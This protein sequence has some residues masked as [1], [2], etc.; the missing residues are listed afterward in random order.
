MK[1]E[2]IASGKD[3]L[4]DIYTES[5]ISDLLKVIKNNDDLEEFI[6]AKDKHNRDKFVAEATL[7]RQNGIVEQSKNIE[8][9]EKK[10]HN[11]QEEKGIYNELT[12]RIKEI[13]DL[14]PKNKQQ[15]FKN[16]LNNI[17]SKDKLQQAVETLTQPKKGFNGFVEKVIHGKQLKEANAK[18]SE[19]MTF[20][21]D[22]DVFESKSELIQCAL[23]EK[24][25]TIAL[26]MA[27]EKIVKEQ[28]NIKQYQQ[29][30][31]I[32][33]DYIQQD[34]NQYDNGPE[35]KQN[36]DK[37]N[38]IIRQFAEQ[39]GPYITNPPKISKEE[40]ANNGL[41]EE[42]IEGQ[43]MQSNYAGN[44]RSSIRRFYEGLDRPAAPMVAFCYGGRT[45]KLAQQEIIDKLEDMGI[46]AVSNTDEKA[47]DPTVFVV[48]EQSIQA[49]FMAPDE[50]LKANIKMIEAICQSEH[51]EHPF[52]SNPL[53]RE[54]L[55]VAV[56]CDLGYN[57]SSENIAM[58]NGSDWERITKGNISEYLVSM[59]QE[60]RDNGQ[61][62]NELD[63][64]NAEAFNKGEAFKSVFHGGKCG[65]PYVVLCNEDNMNFVYGAGGACGD[66]YVS[67]HK[68]DDWSPDGAL[69][70]ALGKS[71]HNKRKLSTGKI[72]YGFLCEYESRGDKQEFIGI[73]RSGAYTFEKGTFDKE[74]VKSAGARDETAILPHQNK[75]KKMY[76]V[77]KVFNE[78]ANI[79]PLEIDEKGQ[80]KDK[81]WRDFVD[82]HQ[83]IDDNLKG[84]M[85]DRRNNMIADYDLG[86]KE[87]FMSRTL[88]DINSQ[89]LNYVQAEKIEFKQSVSNQSNTD[90]ISPSISVYEEITP[91]PPPF[92]QTTQEIAEMS[93]QEQGKIISSM[94]KG[95]NPLLPKDQ[96]TSSVT[97]TKTNTLNI[98]TQILMNRNFSKKI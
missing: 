5:Y 90:I 22:K 72:Q 98:P 37:K 2:F 24:D 7:K 40:I 87:K 50:A 82:L 49:P 27:D 26:Q 63:K 48:T 30:M 54:A 31:Q 85:I 39:K 83:P 38:N 70:Y 62:P 77:T 56:D 66:A 51:A 91:P 43:V 76:I 21:Q 16:V 68:Y 45:D 96:N 33:Q 97:N 55:T 9:S 4:Q 23:T 71:T 74:F 17:Q 78:Q 79:L 42:F 19:L 47:K 81:K 12:V 15:E 95:V 29:K 6:V 86:G 14:Y 89:K 84:F 88:E 13:Q 11:I 58:N 44:V 64:E 10:L 53:T 61:S 28:S 32:L 75:L 67:T 60:A 65:S 94:R 20:C 57:M 8:N 41:S 92:V 69:G 93:S 25:A 34:I 73:D 18:F 80:I 1:N 36:R 59:V 46:N 35:Y 52:L 3:P